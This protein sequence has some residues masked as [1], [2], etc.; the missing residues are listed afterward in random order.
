MFL[1]PFFPPVFLNTCPKIV[2]F[3]VI[4]S[5]KDLYLESR[6]DTF[7]IYNREGRREG[8]RQ[9]VR[10]NSSLKQQHAAGQKHNL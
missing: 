1:F 5:D 3:C 7:I 10:G 6:N 9:I 4:S 8:G 2:S